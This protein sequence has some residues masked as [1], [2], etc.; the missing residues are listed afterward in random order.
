METIKHCTPITGG[1][2]SSVYTSRVSILIERKYGIYFFMQLDS[3]YSRS[4]CIKNI[5]GLIDHNACYFCYKNIASCN[6]DR[7]FSGYLGYVPNLML[8]T[9]QAKLHER[10]WYKEIEKKYG[11]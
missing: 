9:L 11:K 3:E 4:D 7:N 10:K 8:D 2:Y 1:I 5:Q 6:Y